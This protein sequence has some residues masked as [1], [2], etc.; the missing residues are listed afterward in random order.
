MS[1]ATAKPHYGDNPEITHEQTC[2][3]QRLVSLELCAGSGGQALGL[4]RAGFDHTALV[5]IDKHCCNTLRKN[6]PRWNVIQGD[7]AELKGAAYTGIDLLAGGLPCPP[8]SVAGKKLGKNDERDLFPEAVRLTAEIRPRAV[9]LENVKGLLESAFDD[10]REHISGQLQRFGYTTDWRLLTASDF[11]VPQLRPRLVL[12]A[13]RTDLAT[14]FSWPIP[15]GHQPPTVGEVLYDLMA[16]RGWEGA[17]HWREQANDIAPTIVGGST[18][19]G[20]P[21]LG[22]IRARRAWAG[23]GVD[24]LGVADEAPPKGFA[25]VPRLTVPMAARLQGFPDDWHFM[26]GKTAAYRQVGNAFPPPVAQAVGECIRAVL[27]GRGRS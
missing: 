4:E 11:G 2:V 12:V 8:F 19:H 21:D 25:G 26:G 15:N 17:A 27:T 7:V 23:L 5:E 24:G 1:A 6:R 18:K 20:G 22:P 14:H 16:S 3:A 9:M 13:I 10:Y